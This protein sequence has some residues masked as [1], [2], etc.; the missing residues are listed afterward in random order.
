MGLAPG[1]R[2]F[3]R[4]A[5][6]ALRDPITTCRGQLELLSDDPEEQRSTIAL[7]LAELDRMGRI[8]DDL[9]LLADAERDDF[10]RP[11]SIGLELFAHELIEQAAELAP[12]TWT[13][14]HAADGA[15][16]ADRRLLTDAVMSLARNAVQ[17]TES[18]DTIA[19]GTSLVSDEARVW[20]RDTGGGVAADDRR[21]IFDRFARGRGA[22]RRY[23]GGGLG[24][25][26]VRAITEA[27]GGRV[28]LESRLGEGAAFTIV[29][30]HHAEPTGRRT[31]VGGARRAEHKS[32]FH[33]VLIAS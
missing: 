23:R 13:I 17:H 25:T 18:G 2:E 5:S 29:L 31:S 16:V 7:V 24:L 22:H 14:D 32:F 10:L 8:V 3:S 20:V 9:E 6:N 15:V 1:E 33:L 11:E 26:T 30:Q 4:A 12:R 27:H 21:R 28:E 19:I